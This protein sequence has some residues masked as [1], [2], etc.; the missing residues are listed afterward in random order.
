VRED[1][2]GKSNAAGGRVFHETTL[3]N[4]RVR[5][6]GKADLTAA[7]ERTERA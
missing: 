3:E 7:P 4:E 6:D 1:D 5:H 2:A